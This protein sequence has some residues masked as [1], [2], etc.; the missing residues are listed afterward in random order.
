MIEYFF[1]EGCPS[2]EKA[3][4]LLR[5]EMRELGIPES[6]LSVTEV[7]TDEDAQRLQFIG[8][9]TIRIDGEDVADTGDA[10]YGLDCR[11]YYTRA[12]RPSPLPDRD[13]LKEALAA[14]ARKR[15]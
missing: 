5:E 14:H 9:P 1:W 13:D 4:P 2:H 11:L 15:G 3:L 7:L 6:E 8:S 10:T 12:G